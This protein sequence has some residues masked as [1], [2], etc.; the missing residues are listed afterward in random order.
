MPVMC[1]WCEKFLKEKEPLL[2]KTISHDI[3]KECY[4]KD[5]DQFYKEFKERLGKKYKREY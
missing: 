2:D 4:K 3:C 1:S 5:A